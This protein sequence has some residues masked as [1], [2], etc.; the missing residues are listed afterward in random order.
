MQANEAMIKT[1]SVKSSGQQQARWRGYLLVLLAG[2]LWA[3]LGLFFRYL[4][5]YKIPPETIALYRAGIAS[6]ALMA[7][8][9]LR[10]PSMLRLHRRDVPYFLT[11]GVLGV[12]GFFLVYIY[13]VKHGSVAM[14]AVLLY[15]APIWIAL[16]ARW[17]W[18]HPLAG[19]RLAALVLAVA[20]CALVALGSGGPLGGNLLAIV[21]GLGAGLGYAA[22]S[23]WSSEGLRRGYESWTVVSYSMLLGALA[24]L[25]FQSIDGLWWSIT[26]PAVWPALLGVGLVSTLLAPIC[27]TAGIRRIGAPTASIVATVEPVIAAML[28]WAIL[29]EAL[30]PE[31]I[32]GGLSIL[33]AI[34][35]LARSGEKEK[36]TDFPEERMITKRRKST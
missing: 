17:R 23:L 1:G 35:I 2:S 33:A 18:G 5:R 15:T 26:T 30:T 29:G 36:E 6:L 24:M 3:T 31:Q 13:A 22:Y 9:A 19:A 14:A 4:D 25:P 10:R 11:F 20:G 27:Y 32:A 28:A 7:F 34:I 21:L 12:A 8:W 16:F